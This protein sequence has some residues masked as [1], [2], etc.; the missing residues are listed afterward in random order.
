MLC[1][2][3]KVSRKGY[4]N[5]LNRPPKSNIR[6]ELVTSTFRKYHGKQGV[7]Q[8]KLTIALE[9]GIRMN[10]KAIRRIMHENRLE[11]KIRRKKVSFRNIEICEAKENVLNRQFYPDKPN[12][13][14][15][16]DFTYLNVRGV[17]YYLS[18]MLD[19]FDKTPIVWYL[20]DSCGK[21]LSLET[22]KLLEKKVDLKDCLIHSD[23]GIQ[24]TCKA[25]CDRLKE[26]G[27]HQSMSG[28]G[29]CWDNARIENFFGIIKTETIYLQP[30]RAKSLESLIEM[31]EE[32][33][34]Y[35]INS[36][37]QKS[38]GGAPPRDYRER[39]YAMQKH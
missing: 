1:R 16:T 29:N 2:I 33:I 4:Y 17:T 34:D 35:Y 10:H 15:C 11:C 18:A 27:V 36:R 6:E 8:L 13:C 7:L 24:Y 12:K 14:F 5:W 3:A 25:Y 9:Y 28:K 22:L 21:D 23:R 30:K 19:M 32:E 20:T 38:L 31:I 37:P 39:Y 26:L